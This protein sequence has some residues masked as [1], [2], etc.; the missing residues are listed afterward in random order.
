MKHSLLS[1]G[2]G[3]GILDQLR[4][5][6][7]VSAVCKYKNLFYIYT[8]LDVCYHLPAKRWKRLGNVGLARNERAQLKAPNFTR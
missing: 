1:S 4:R 5:S 3:W 6:C 7:P 8:G 2:R